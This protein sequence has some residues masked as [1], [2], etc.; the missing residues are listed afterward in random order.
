MSTRVLNDTAVAAA[1]PRHGNTTGAQLPAGAVCLKL[2][3]L[4]IDHRAADFPARFIEF[5]EQ[6]NLYEM[7]VNSAGE[8]LILP[9]TGYRGNK[10]EFY[11]AVFPGKLGNRARR[12]RVFTDGSVSACLPAR[13]GGPMPRGLRR[14]GST[15][16]RK[17]SGK[18][19]SK[20]PPTSWLKSALE[21]TPCV[22]CKTRWFCGWRAAP[23]LGWLIDAPQPAGLYLSRRPDRSATAQRPGNAGRGGRAAWLFLP[24]SAV[25]LRPALML[26]ASMSARV[27]NGNENRRRPPRGS[28]DWRSRTGRLRRTH[29]RSGCR[30]RGQ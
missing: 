26:L 12:Q 27:L 7:E 11:F 14:N 6:N 15:P 16:C 23:R 8:L 19:L 29:S 25:H 1:S 21:P 3:A 17:T 4:G 30:P 24:G 9:M 22:R 10:E 20:A 18:R 5:C 13:S 2:S 28:R